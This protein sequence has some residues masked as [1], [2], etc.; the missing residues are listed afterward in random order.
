[1]KNHRGSLANI[2]AALNEMRPKLVRFAMRLGASHEDAEDAV[3]DTMLAVLKN[4]DAFDGESTFDTWVMGILKLQTITTYRKNSKYVGGEEY[5]AAIGR[6][7]V[8]PAQEVHVE[9]FELLDRVDALTPEKRHALLAH[10]LG[11]THT[12]VA[13]QCGVP[14]A[15]VKTRVHY[16]RADIEDRLQ[17]A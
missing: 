11:F 17:V 16:A 12:E 9:L 4:S 5:D 2:G 7:L 15:T 8:G 3:Q 10:S 1:M 6:C 14:V 13:N